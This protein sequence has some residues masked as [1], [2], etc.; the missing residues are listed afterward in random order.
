MSSKSSFP[1]TCARDETITIRLGADSLIRS[2]SRF[3]SRKCPKW[4]TP[5]CVSK[6]SSVSV[7]G[8][9]ITP[10]LLMRTCI[11]SSSERILLAKARMDLHEARS[12]CRNRTLS[13]P[14]LSRTSA[15]AFS[16]LSTLRQARIILPPR[17]FEI[18]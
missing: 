17:L 14:L 3:V 9:N 7:Y 12:S 8:T 13:L 2:R 15:T 4:L 11:S 18:R 16:P 5:K 10:A 1:A 6:P